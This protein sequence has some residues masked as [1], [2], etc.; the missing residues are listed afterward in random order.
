MRAPHERPLF[1]L[2]T[3]LYQRV[4]FLKYW[5]LRRGYLTAAGWIA[6]NWANA[7]VARD[8]APVAWY[9][10]PALSFLEGRIKPDMRVFEFG[11]GHSTRWWAARTSS[12]HAVEDDRAWYERLIASGLPTNIDLQYEVGEDA[13][14]QSIAARGQSFDVVVIDGS[15]RIECT[16]ACL[17]WLSA[18]G[19]V[20]WD[21]SE[22]DQ[23]FGPAFEFL[24]ERGFRRI[25]FHGLAP[26]NMDAH[27]TSVF[28]RAAS[29][30]FGI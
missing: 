28:Y 7:P 23:A 25:D 5:G 2:I 30:C 8:G 16:F 29:N 10:Y 19:V 26:L 14:V 15:H 3:W 22:Q 17:S 12:V 6:S 18:E 27:A 1:K 4:P 9:T 13:Y 20:V 11:S 21:N 24:A